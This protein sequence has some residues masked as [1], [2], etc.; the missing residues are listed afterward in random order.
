MNQYKV[1]LWPETVEGM[2]EELCKIGGSSIKPEVT[3]MKVPHGYS[4]VVEPNPREFFSH[5]LH[6]ALKLAVE[7][8]R[9]SK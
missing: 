9:T 5:T 1:V 3:I 2:I 6:A 8:K 4:V 7:A